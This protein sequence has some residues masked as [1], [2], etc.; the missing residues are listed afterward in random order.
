[1]NIK[2]IATHFI[3]ATAILSSLN[4]NAISMFVVGDSL[5]DTGNI[6]YALRGTTI[7]PPYQDLIPLAAYSSER[8]SNGS[9]WAETLAT[10][11]GINLQA[12]LIGGT[13][14]A[15]G[16]ARTGSLTGIAPSLIPT[17]TD[18]A[19]AIVDLSGAL[20]TTDLFVVWGGANDIRD[21]AATKDAG[22]ATTII[23]DSLTNITDIITSLA[24]E[25]AT[26][27]LVPNLPD[28]GLTPSAQLAGPLAAGFITQ[29]TEQFNDTLS[30]TLLPGLEQSL[31]VDI[32]DLNI[33]GLLDDIVADP[34]NF[35][36]SNVTDAC[37]QIG[38]G[39]CSAPDD[40]LFWDG[41]HPTSA[42]HTIIADAAFAALVPIPATLPFF[43]AALS[44]LGLCSGKKRQL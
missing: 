25:G 29:L 39:A 37:I 23:R 40:Y 33:E 6:F 35:G 31:S 15:Y 43:I 42:T 5:S 12:S 44:V 2:S 1:M 16:G 28:L 32:I 4:V 10:N 34:T 3:G 7:N 17:L 13:G 26:R 38:D 9:I 41:I 22:Q 8:L 11:L 24:N 27:F 20:S 18:Q 36:L 19:Q 14:Y 21:A 30:S